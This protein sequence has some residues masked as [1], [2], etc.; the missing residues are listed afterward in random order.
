MNI[1][2]VPGNVLG[3]GFKVINKVNK[4]SAFM[5]LVPLSTK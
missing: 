4:L 3:T 2:C 1:Y 5:E